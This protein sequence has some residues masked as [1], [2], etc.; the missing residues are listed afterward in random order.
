MENRITPNYEFAP[1][2]PQRGLGS[3]VWDV[4]GKEYVDLAGGI[5]VNALGHCH[6]KLIEALDVQARRL[7]HISNVY[8]NL[9]AMELAQKLTDRTF[10]D[11]VFFSNSGAEANEAALKMARK[12]QSDRFGD[13]K[14]EIVSAL[15]SFHGRSLFTVSVG[16][17]AKYSDG[18]G[19]LPQSIAHVP[20]ND[21][22]ALRE[23]VGER[24]CC[25]ILEP[26]QGESGALP[27]TKE[28]L[29][30]A[31]EA[32]DAAGALLIF[33]EVQCGMGRS[34]ELYAYMRYGVEP[35][36]LTSAK[37]LGGGF[38]IGATLAKEQVARCFAPGSHGS[39]FGGNPL[40]CAVACAAFDLIDR[41]ETRANVQRQ[42]D[43]LMEGLRRL[44][45]ELSL[46]KDV[47]GMGLLVGAELSDEFAGKA[48]ALRLECLKQGAMVLQAGSDVLRFAPSLLISDEDLDE[49]LKRVGEGARAFAQ[50][51]RGA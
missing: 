49:G 27:A 16:G 7:W 51:A 5:A 6:P 47:R 39:T 24:A 42:S 28:Y 12:F 3:R 50:A 44:G 38:P 9:P 22:Q 20:F 30:A 48:K 1:M 41:E 21:P 26:I 43:R 25:V 4:E 18:F 19:P 17:Q 40:A 15:R 37:A 14:T 35:D 34:G 46:F 13:K 10:A 2:I 23:A 8:A 33:D 32:C 31:R 36:I 29:Q 45:E 11:R